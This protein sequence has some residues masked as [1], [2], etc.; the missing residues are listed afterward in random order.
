[1]NQ[2]EYRE[3]LQ[4]VK[5]LEKEIQQIDWE[6]EKIAEELED[7]ELTEQDVDKEL[8]RLKKVIKSDEIKYRKARRTFDKKYSAAIESMS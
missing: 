2:T 8:T 3:A 7:M 6:L 5:Q 1:M 4:S